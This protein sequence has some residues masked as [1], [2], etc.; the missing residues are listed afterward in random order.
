MRSSADIANEIAAKEKELSTALDKEQEI[1]QSI[2][3]LQ[4]DILEKQHAKKE[5]EITDS[6]A[7]NIIKKLNI[8]LRLLRSEFW[9]CKNSGC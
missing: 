5:L 6:K 2:L 3:L 8:E 9:S 1:E 7:K 4:R